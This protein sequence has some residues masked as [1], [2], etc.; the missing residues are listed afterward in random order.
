M[1]PWRYRATFLCWLRGHDE[2]VWQ[3]GEKGIVWQCPDCKRSSPSVLKHLKPG[4]LI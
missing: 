3:C 1:W 2:P 4:H